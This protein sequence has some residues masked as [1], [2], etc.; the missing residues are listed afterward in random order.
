M[1]RSDLS[2][3]PLFYVT[4]VSLYCVLLD[5]EIMHIPAT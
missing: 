3:A 4:K 1:E 2:K 5:G